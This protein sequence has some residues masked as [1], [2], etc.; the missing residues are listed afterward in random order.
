MRTASSFYPLSGTKARAACRSPSKEGEF[1]LTLYTMA[2]PHAA[3]LVHLTTFIHRIDHVTC[4]VP[5]ICVTAGL[6]GAGQD[7]NANCNTATSSALLAGRECY[8]PV[9]CVLYFGTG[10]RRNESS[11]GLYY[12]SW[13]L[14]RVRHSHRHNHDH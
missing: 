11:F 9:T 13:L 3:L 12:G 8:S 5:T 6:N 7:K 4:D 14:N 1:A 2:A 10:I